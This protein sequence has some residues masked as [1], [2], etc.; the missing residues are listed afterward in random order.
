M[1]EPKVIGLAGVG[2]Q[3]PDVGVAERF[4]G[5]FGLASEKRGAA[6]GLRSPGRSA[7]EIVVLPGTAQKRLHHVS[8]IIRPGDEDAFEEKLRNAGLGTQT[9]PDGVPRPGLWFQ[10]PWGTWINLNPGMSPYQEE[11]KEKA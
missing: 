10:D 9:A 11:S 8:F 3:V 1:N 4:Y 5:A 2:L 6:L 7:D